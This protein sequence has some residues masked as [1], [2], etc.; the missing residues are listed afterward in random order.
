MVPFASVKASVAQPFFDAVPFAVTK[1][2]RWAEEAGLPGEMVTDPRGVVPLRAAERFMVS[3]DKRINHPTFFIETLTG[4]G[5]SQTASVA[6]IPLPRAITGIEALETVARRISSVLHGA[7]FLT[8]RYG[9]YVWLLRTAGTTDW[10]DYWPV[11]QYNLAVGVQA[12]QQVLGRRITPQALRLSRKVHRS[13]LPEAWRDLPI[14]LSRRTLG[15]A[16]KLDDVRFGSGDVIT[17]G[18]E[19][20]IQS[21]SGSGEVAELRGCMES[22]LGRSAP[23]RL[24]DS[25]AKAFG[26]SVRSYRRHLERIGLT[27][28]QLVSDARLYR[29]EAMLADH[30]IPITEIAFELGYAHSSAFT[31]FFKERTGRTPQDHRSQSS[32]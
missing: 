17:C 8:E 14:F 4:S 2:E 10:T 21:R 6:N 19:K 12:I 24:A 13:V 23:E 3:L 26:M 7:D 25:M 20:G 18:P 1:V 29:A 11:Q 32:E 5:S 28:R 16:F 30:S 22:Y 9:N 31:R 27:H 15:V